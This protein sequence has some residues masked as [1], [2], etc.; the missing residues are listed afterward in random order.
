MNTDHSLFTGAVRTAEEI[1]TCLYAM[2]NDP[3]VTV[4]AS[5]SQRMDSALKRIEIMGNPVNN[6]F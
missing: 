3:A 2:P 6:D 5:G 1:S 4:A